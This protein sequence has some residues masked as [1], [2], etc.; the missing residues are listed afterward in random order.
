MSVRQIVSVCFSPLEERRRE[1]PDQRTGGIETQGK[2][3]SLAR[4][5]V[6]LLERGQKRIQC[7]LRPLGVYE[8]LQKGNHMGR[9][10]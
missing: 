7:A 6:V 10:E 5:Q 9:N 3:H 2:P 4:C 8:Q 1:K